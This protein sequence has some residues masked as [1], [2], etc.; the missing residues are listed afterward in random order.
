M[1]RSVTGSRVVPRDEHAPPTS[2]VVS[3]GLEARAVSLRAGGLAHGRLLVECCSFRV[4]AGERSRR[5][6]RKTR[7]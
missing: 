1:K 6:S 4:Q 7:R 5:R 3:A 2:A